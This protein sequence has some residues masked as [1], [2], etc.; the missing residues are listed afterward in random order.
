M[1]F[2]G[3]CLTAPPSY[4]FQANPPNHGGP[5]DS[6]E[7]LSGPGPSSVH[8]PI[9]LARPGP[10]PGPGHGRRPSG[11]GH[12]IH[13]RPQQPMPQPHLRPDVAGSSSH[14]V[15]SSGRPQGPP[16]H[17]YQHHNQNPK[18][19]IVLKVSSKKVRPTKLPPPPPPFYA[20][21]PDT[22]VSS[23][24]VRDT[25]CYCITCIITL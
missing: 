7:Y 13:R 12:R 6:E 24:N 10:G 1:Y 22:Q 3:F 20:P 14:Y 21:S 2:L 18:K 5:P 11:P 23:H 9:E 19:P 8:N 4:Q 25:L 15:P 17:H 16:P